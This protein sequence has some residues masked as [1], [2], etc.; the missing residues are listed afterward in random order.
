[1]VSVFAV[2]KVGADSGYS[3]WTALE[4]QFF[5]GSEDILDSV[6]YSTTPDGKVAILLPPEFR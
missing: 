4:E 1:M 3:E 6:V 2:H 5:I